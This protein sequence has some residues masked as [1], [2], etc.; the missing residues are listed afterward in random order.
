MWIAGLQPDPKHK[1]GT[2]FASARL[3]GFICSVLCG[4]K[5]I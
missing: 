2:H 3:L 1:P 4:I 5:Q